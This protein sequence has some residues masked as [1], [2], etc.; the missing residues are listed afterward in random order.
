MAIHTYTKTKYNEIPD[1]IKYRIIKYNEELGI[2]QF[3]DTI[4]KDPKGNTLQAI[5]PGDKAKIDAFLK[6]K[7]FTYQGAT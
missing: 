6:Q 4:T 3:D 1:R 2:V 5:Q 7:G